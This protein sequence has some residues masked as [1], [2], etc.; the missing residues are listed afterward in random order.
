MSTPYHFRIDASNSPILESNEF[1]WKLVDRNQERQEMPE[2]YG[3][4]GIQAT[5]IDDRAGGRYRPFFETEFDLAEMRSFSRWFFNGTEVGAGL[6]R[7]MLDFVVGNG[8]EI[9]AVARDRKGQDSQL[10]RFAN[11]LIDD[12]CEENKW[13]EW[14]ET[15]FVSRTL[16]DGESILVLTD[17]GGITPRTRLVGSDQLRQPLGDTSTIEDHYQ[18]PCGLDW[19]F[20]VATPPNDTSRP[21]AYAVS[22][23]ATP[24][25][26]DVFS[27]SQVVHVR[28]NVPSDVKRGIP[29]AYCA[30]VTIERDSKLMSHIAQQAA[31]QS[32]I[33][34]I[35]EHSAGMN[36]GTI[37]DAVKRSTQAGPATGSPRTE[38]YYPGKI[39][40]TTANTKYLYGP[41]GQPNG[42]QFLQVNQAL[43]RRIGMRWGLPEFM[44]S[45]DASNG[46][47]SSTMMTGGPFDRAM[48]RRQGFHTRPIVETI[49]KAFGF[50]MRKGAFER[51]GVFTLA[52]LK[53]ILQVTADA[54]NASV[55]DPSIQEQVRKTRSEAG[56]LS[57]KTW[58]TEAGLDYDAERSN[59]DSEPKPEQPMFPG[60]AGQPGQPPSVQQN[61]QNALE[62]L[63]HFCRMSAA[64]LIEDRSGFDPKQPRANDGRTE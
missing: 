20:G 61:T 21:M 14:L 62:S 28:A 46:N 64:R 2:F 53:R 10:L 36:T 4:Y 5:Q 3:R 31:I 51:F 38:R 24:A 7:T 32:S 55:N 26:Y 33:S 6:I 60:V 22:W 48:E 47:Y 43:Q 11:E 42:P 15:E 59:I 13:R 40:D 17:E 37:Q 23:D 41:M 9:T 58:A 16:E 56:I 39:I 35:R 45:G 19:W 50:A 57:K 12:F 27:P 44:V 25:N 54:P 49:W 1:A 34:G 8:I 29:D 18:L 63:E 30:A 52:E